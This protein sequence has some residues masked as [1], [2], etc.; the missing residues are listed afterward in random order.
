M[1]SFV[2]VDWPVAGNGM[3]VAAV[4]SPGV[5]LSFARWVGERSKMSTDQFRKFTIISLLTVYARGVFLSFKKSQF[6]GSSNWD[7][8]FHLRIARP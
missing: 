8:R 1:L 3:T 7:T 6:A 4:V 2:V 5:S